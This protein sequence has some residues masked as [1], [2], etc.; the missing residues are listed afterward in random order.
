MAK[1]IQLTTYEKEGVDLTVY[2]NF[3]DEP[4]QRVFFLK[5]LKQNSVRGGKVSAV[6]Y[7]G[8]VCI[9]GFCTVCIRNKDGES[10]YHLNN[11]NTCLIIEPNEWHQISQFEDDSILL[12]FSNKKYNEF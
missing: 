12:A 9:Q 1:I 6:G 3:L 5:N 10:T 8:I 7:E 2:E 11:P 4:I